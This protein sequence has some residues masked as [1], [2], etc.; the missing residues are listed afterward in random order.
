[1][2]RDHSEIAE[3]I[4]SDYQYTVN[5]LAEG[6]WGTGA[7]EELV[8]MGYEIRARLGTHE[9]RMRQLAPE[10][11]RRYRGDPVF[12][13]AVEC[14]MQQVLRDE[15]DTEP[16]WSVPPTPYKYIERA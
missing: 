14:I 8:D 11:L 6:N 13:A 7:I 15:R 16:D 12:H 10:I 4:A 3:S 5:C 1:M 2:S 9:E